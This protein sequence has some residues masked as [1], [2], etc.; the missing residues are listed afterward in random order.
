VIPA[1]RGVVTAISVLTAAHDFWWSALTRRT[2]SIDLYRVAVMSIN[3]LYKAP[4]SAAETR[5]SLESLKALIDVLITKLPT[6]E[7][8]YGAQVSE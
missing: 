3:E 8:Q 2:M 5:V 4:V 7:D 1:L 6:E